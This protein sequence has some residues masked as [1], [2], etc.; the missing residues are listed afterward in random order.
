MLRAA[1]QCPC[2]FASPTLHALP[3]QGDRVISALAGGRAERSWALNALCL[4]SCKQDL[5][6]TATPGLLPALLPVRGR[7]ALGPALAPTCLPACQPAQKRAT[8]L[9]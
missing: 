8:Q 5:R 3:V 7:R 6:L 1:K 9:S 2:P 4:L